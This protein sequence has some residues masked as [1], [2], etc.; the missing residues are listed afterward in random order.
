[1]KFLHVIHSDKK[2]VKPAV[3]FI[4]ECVNCGEHTIMYVNEKGKDSLI[5]ADSKL[6]QIEYYLNNRLDFVTSFKIIKIMKQYDYIVFHSLYFRF[7]FRLIV[8]F[9]KSLLKK[10]VWIEFGND[11][12]IK[13]GFLRGLT[14]ILTRIIANN[15][16]SFVGIFEPDCEYFERKY[17]KSNAKIFFAPYCGPEVPDFFV[18]RMVNNNIP[19]EKKKISKEEVVIQI[20]HN[21]MRSLNHIK[22]LNTLRRFRNENI[23]ILLILNYG[24]SKKYR[25]RV[26]RYA[27]KCFPGKVKYLK[28]FLGED[29]YYKVIDNVDICIFN[30]YRQAALANINRM[31]WNNVKMY[32]PS[33]SVMFKFF[34]DN[35]AA[36]EKYEE[37]A[38]VSFEEFVNYPHNNSIDLEKYKKRYISK[39]WREGSWNY[40]YERLNK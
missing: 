27:E 17:A 22:V 28:N 8:C 29:E 33:N 25:D 16:N 30:T 13:P 14:Y 40:I 35:G 6:K 15:C 36:V 24:D 26:Q 5:L 38:I 20:G 19:L 37:I 32:I 4:E 1:M 9:H 12:Y 31:I 2:F 34:K 21:G 11:L 18:D 23:K 7:V 39:E 3:G 10:I